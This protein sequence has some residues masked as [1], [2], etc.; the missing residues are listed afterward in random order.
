MGD[1]E[2][3]SEL[4]SM[5]EESKSLASQASVVLALSFIGDKRSIDPLISLLQNKGVSDRARGFA[6]ASLGM[7]ADKSILPWNSDLSCD[8]NYRASTVTLNDTGGTGILNIL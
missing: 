3:V 2:L 1:Y 5:L 7:V 4:I 6:A 8:L